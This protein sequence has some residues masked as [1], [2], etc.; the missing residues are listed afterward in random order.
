MQHMVKYFLTTD[1]QITQH[2]I[3]NI[4]EYGIN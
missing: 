3:A 1:K 4:Q 2:A